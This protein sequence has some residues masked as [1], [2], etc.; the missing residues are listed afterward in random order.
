[1]K[2]LIFLYFIL[3]NSNV[4]AQATQL[5]SIDKF[6]AQVKNNHPVAKQANN[7][8]LQ[9]DAN[10]MIANGAF[11]PIVDVNS[12]QKN[13]QG[14]QYYNYN[15]AELKYNTPIGIGV[16]TGVENVGGVYSNTE[17]T[18]GTASYIGLEVQVLKGLLIDKNRAALRKAKVMQQQSVQEKNA[19]RNDLLFDA[20]VSYWQWAAQYQLYQIYDGYVQNAKQRFELVKLSYIQGDRAQADT[21]EAATQLQSFELMQTEAMLQ[22]QNASFELA[23]YLWSE[24]GQPEILASNIVPDTNAFVQIREKQNSETLLAAII[25]TNPNLNVYEYKLQQ[26][27]VERQLKKQNRLPSLTVQANALHKNYFGSPNA[28]QIGLQNNNKFG[29]QFKMPILLR[30]SRG[31]F[32]QVLLKINDTKWQQENKIWMLQNKVQQYNTTSNLLLQQLQQIEAMII[33]YQFLVNNENLKFAQ[34]ETTIFL[35]N[36]REIK[37]LEMQQKQIE[38]RVKYVKA[39]FA[40]LWASGVLQ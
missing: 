29:V 37:M 18:K 26:L 11:D 23:Q 21:V 2:K 1:M 24:S 40:T 9:A 32:E 30:E 4:F 20:Y 31:E 19:I 14:I 27:N 39:Y 7:I 25:K 22:L 6:I 28:N 34:G 17:F 15:N 33:N 12:D 36:T 38:L 35:I 5:L 10:R 16:K 3:Y 13:L 8:V